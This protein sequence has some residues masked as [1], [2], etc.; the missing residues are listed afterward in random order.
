MSKEA[1]EKLFMAASENPDLMA[2]LESADSYAEAVSIGAENGF[3]F[4]EEE[5]ELFLAEY[6]LDKGLNGELS[7]EDL[8]AVAGGAVTPYTPTIAKVTFSITSRIRIR[9]W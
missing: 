3:N 4:T 1:V 6:G 5:A 7:E 9:R 8:E 2:K